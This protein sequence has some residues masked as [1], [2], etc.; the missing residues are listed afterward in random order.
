[1]ILCFQGGNRFFGKSGCGEQAEPSG[2]L[3]VLPREDLRH[4][5]AVGAADQDTRVDV[6]ILEKFGYPIR[7]G[8]IIFKLVGIIEGQNSILRFQRED[9]WHVEVGKAHP[10]DQKDQRDVPLPAKQIV[11][12][13]AIDVLVLK[14]MSSQEVGKF[15]LIRSC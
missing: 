2:L 6:Q 11:I 3:R 4:V 14:R 13:C 15:Y 9:I 10:A 8:L 1:M 12:I 7:Q 5:P